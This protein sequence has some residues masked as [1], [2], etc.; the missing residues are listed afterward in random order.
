MDQQYS[1]TPPSAAPAPPVPPSSSKEWTWKETLTVIF[2]VLSPLIG[3]ILMWV[4]ANW[5]RKAKIIITLVL[6]LGSIIVSGISYTSLSSTR[7]A[8]RDAV[9][10]A[11][12][13][14][15]V[16]AQEMYYAEN[17]AYYISVSYPSKIGFYMPETPTDP[18]T[19]GPY[20][21]IDNTRDNQK[22][23]AYADLER[24]GFYIASHKGN[25]EIATEPR[26]LS[27]CEKIAH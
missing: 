10:K 17:D 1:T 5:S 23:C 2:L 13:Y 25:G 26:T 22:F 21:W 4:L 20:G 8:A 18:K 24:G 11:D 7:K 27:D 16:T 14:Q 12:M 19:G 3:L 9:R 6:L 15:I